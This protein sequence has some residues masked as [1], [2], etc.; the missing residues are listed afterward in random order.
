VA[1]G[2]T[3]VCLKTHMAP[4]RVVISDQNVAATALEGKP[5]AER[6]AANIA[7]GAGSMAWIAD[8]ILDGVDEDRQMKRQ[9]G[10]RCASA[11]GAAH[12]VVFPERHVPTHAH[13]EP[14]RTSMAVQLMWPSQRHR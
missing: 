13:R 1:D 12:M 10:S 3:K 4:Q 6:I 14:N 5:A 11:G 8:E 2:V 7:D 9:I